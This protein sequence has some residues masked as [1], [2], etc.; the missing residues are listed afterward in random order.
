MAVFLFVTILTF[1]LYEAITL[2]RRTWPNLSISV[3]SAFVVIVTAL[4]VLAFFKAGAAIYYTFYATRYGLEFFITDVLFG[5]HFFRIAI[6][7]I[8]GIV[9]GIVLNSILLGPA[10]AKISSA[11]KLTVGGKVILAFFL[12]MFVFGITAERLLDDWALRVSK[13]SFAGAEVTF[14]DPAQLRR[15]RP[16]GDPSRVGGVA[17]TNPAANGPAIALDFFSTLPGMIER[18]RGYIE[19]A[20][21]K[22]SNDLTVELLGLARAERFATNTFSSPIG[23]CLHEIFRQTGDIHFVRGPLSNLLPPLRN[24]AAPAHPQR[25]DHVVDQ[26]ASAYVEFLRKL[27][28]YAYEQGYRYRKVGNY[29]NSQQIG[30][31]CAAIV[32]LFCSEDEWEAKHHAIRG[33]GSAWHL[34]VDDASGCH[35]SASA[36]GSGFTRADSRAGRLEGRCAPRD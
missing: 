2:V 26:T 27:F 35:T 24:L 5:T 23:K 1:A 31:S 12:V 3:Y 8:C 19:S 28:V 9:A 29:P 18:D 22:P 6:G 20:L 21:T 11:G 13:L 15:N 33:P 7:L 16:E 4:A 14:F 36:G 30:E 25:I 17:H 10:D 32:Y 34:P